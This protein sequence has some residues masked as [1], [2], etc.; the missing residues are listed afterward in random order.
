MEFCPDYSS[1][2]QGVGHMDK[3]YHATIE[4]LKSHCVPKWF[5]DAKFGI[6]IHWGLYSV[7]GYAPTGSLI[8]MLKTDYDR[9][10][11]IYP[12]AEGYWNAIK[13]PDTPSAKYHK[14]KYGD[15]PYQGFKQLF[16]DGLKFWD[17][18]DWAKKFKSAGA[19]YVVIVS[20]HHDGYCLWPTKIENPYEQEWFSKRDI[21]GELA[22]AVRGEGMRFGI[23]YS[24]G[25]DWTFR[26]RIS[27][28]L[29]D[30]S[31]S[32]PGRKYATY[33]DAQVRELIS[34]YQPDI[35]WNDIGW[36]TGKKPLFRLFADY[37]NTVP[38]G[39]INDRWKNISR[40][41]G[42]KP[43]RSLMDLIIKQAISK[44]TDIHSLLLP[45]PVPHS[46]FTT[47]EYMKYNEIKLKKWE[48]T[49]G[50]GNSFGYNRNET[51]K[52]Y[53]SFETLLT[54]FVDT[55]SKNGNLLLNVGPRGDDAQIPDVQ[56]SRLTE[57]GQWLNH[58]GD[59]IYATRPWKQADAI[60]ETGEAVR[61]TQKDNKLFIMFLSQPKENVIKIKD[62][63]IIGDA[64]LLDNNSPVQ[65][66]NIGSDTVITLSRQLKNTPI[67][68]IVVNIN[69]QL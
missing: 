64:Y 1:N 19:K 11:L 67:P 13:D 56:L 37:Y 47:P 33:A 23:Y 68:T 57:F 18:N 6:F 42:Y 3:E 61:F 22:E 58:S 8:E 55:V 43:V 10:M 12:Y 66:G 17:P 48:M 46:D 27:R 51:D 20:K 39:V 26:K 7:P 29:M 40:L 49:R 4:T 63:S 60:T 31:F 16:E 15:M 45:H 34:R 9:A 36:P 5:E 62:I 44:T 38:E 69:R 2:K 30:Y 24:G 52:D 50:M 53:S 41:M 21:I 35:L 59:A 28:T 14:A 65:I 25:I 54:D 32:V